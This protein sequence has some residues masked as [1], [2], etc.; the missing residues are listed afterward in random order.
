M[1]IDNGSLT[2]PFVGIENPRTTVV[3][4]SLSEENAVILSE[5]SESKDLGTI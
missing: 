2:I 4:M 1:I 3:A 5:R